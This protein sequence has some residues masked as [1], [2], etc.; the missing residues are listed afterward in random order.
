M[1]HFLTFYYDATIR[2]LLLPPPRPRAAAAGGAERS[3]STTTT[4]WRRSVFL[5]L[6]TTAAAANDRR[7]RATTTNTIINHRYHYHRYY[8]LVPVSAASFHYVA[9]PTATPPSSR[10]LLFEA[11]LPLWWVCCAAR[12]FLSRSAAPARRRLLH[13]AVVESAADGRLVVSAVHPDSLPT[14]AVPQPRRGVAGRRHLRRWNALTSRPADSASQ[15]QGVQGRF[16]T[17]QV[18]SVHREHAV[19]HPALVALQ[20]PLQLEPV[21]I[22]QLHRAIAGCSGKKPHIWAE[23]AL[24]DV[25]VM[26]LR[27]PHAAG[28][29]AWATG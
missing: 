19:P 18:S 5:P 1:L 29:P 22:P 9:G 23:Q 4:N 15:S 16:S 28:R 10:N 3:S 14:G 6:P 27:P 17:C 11:P 7:A 8:E 26:R 13:C 25:A 12:R 21:Q 2:H 24:Q 20:N